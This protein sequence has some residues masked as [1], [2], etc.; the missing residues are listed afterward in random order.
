MTGLILK[1][2]LVM[3]KT[4]KTYIL[5]LAFYAAMAVMGIFSLGFVVAFLQVIVMMLPLS[6]FAYDEQAKWDRYAM[7]LPIGRR[8]VVT[9]R[10]LFVLLMLLSAAAFGMAVCV[11]LSFT[12]SPGD[13]SEYLATILVSMGAG[14]VIADI[15]LPLNYKLGPERARPYLYAVVFLPIIALFGASKLGFL[16]QLNLSGLNDLSQSSILGLFALIPLVALVG[17]GVSYLVS[18]RIVENKEF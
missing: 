1:D 2:A 17:L 4:L 15:L 14:M 13:L 8:A 3:R 18:C 6:A 12:S 11:L 9:A 7:T 16:D 10:Y 5:F